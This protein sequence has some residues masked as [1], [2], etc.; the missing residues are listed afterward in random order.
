MRPE[1]PE[2]SVLIVSR[3][4]G[5]QLRACLQSLREQIDPPKWELVVGANGD[6]EVVL[7][8]RELF[9]HAKVEVIP[10]AHPGKARNSAI[11]RA[12]GKTI[13]FLDDDIQADPDLLRRLGELLAARPDVGVF[14]G[15]N[16]TPPNSSRFQVVQGAVLSSLIS[17]GPVRRR[18]G[19]HP[20]RFADERYFMLCNMAVRSGVLV[21]FDDTL[22]CAEENRLLNELQ[23][24]GVRMLYD[25]SLIVF[26]DRRSDLKSFIRQLFKYGIGRGQLTSRD[27][28][29]IRPAYLAPLSLLLYVAALPI[30]ISWTPW[31]LLGAAVYL[32]LLTVNGLMVAIT[33]RK[34]SAFVPAAGLTSVI[35]V[36]YAVGIIAGLWRGAGRKIRG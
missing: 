34:P 30:L 5:P 2:I 26:H 12:S 17:S 7:E 15:P 24:I 31:W 22:I 16:L 10:R 28:T 13:L 18:Y 20:A 9:P 21:Q 29:S 35:H 33:L 6:P 1:D 25:P 32:V 3:T 8:V 4:R 36:V 14:G 11:K 19:P 23:A 27:P